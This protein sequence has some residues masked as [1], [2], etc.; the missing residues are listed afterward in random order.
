MIED[1]LVYFIS[2]FISD[3]TKTDF[4]AHIY[5]IVNSSVCGPNWDSYTYRCCT[6]FPFKLS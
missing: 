6:V 5:Q 4:I 3:Y 1:Y 2:Y